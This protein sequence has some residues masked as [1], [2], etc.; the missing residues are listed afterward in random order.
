MSMVG[1]TAGRGRGRTLLLMLLV[2][3]MDAGEMLDQWERN[4]LK[5]ED[6]GCMG[7][8]CLQQKHRRG[9]EGAMGGLYDHCGIWRG[10]DEK[11]GGEL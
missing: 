3:M 5:E 7:M 9:R 8:I 10:G 6:D 4:V 1:S 2:V 11:D